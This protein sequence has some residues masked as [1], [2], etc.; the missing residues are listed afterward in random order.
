M[1]GFRLW[2]NVAIEDL[3]RHLQQAV[4]RELRR[5]GI[6]LS[7]ENRMKLERALKRVLNE[8]VY[9]SPACGTSSL[10]RPSEE[11]R[12]KPWSSQSA[13]WGLVQVADPALERE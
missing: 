7:E 3:L 10:C 1:A 13:A 8:D 2:E 9:A 6:E 12:A 11:G 4:L 5:E